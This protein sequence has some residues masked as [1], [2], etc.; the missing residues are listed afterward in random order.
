MSGKLENGDGNIKFH[1]KYSL[2]FDL[3]KKSAT[4]KMFL[5]SYCAV[6]MKSFFNLGKIQ[7][8]IS[9]GVN[10]IS[11]FYQI[12]QFSTNYSNPGPQT[13]L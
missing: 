5:A 13:R 9:L 8:A 2:Q 3:S 10:L 1:K 7:G 4:Y 6:S 11:H 12:S